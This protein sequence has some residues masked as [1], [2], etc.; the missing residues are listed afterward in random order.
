MK[1]M[2]TRSKFDVKSYQSR[3]K[4]DK[5]AESVRICFE[6]GSTLVWTDCIV[7]YEEEH[8]Y[9][10]GEGKQLMKLSKSESKS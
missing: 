8:S 3:T 2:Q 4:V 7:K 10:E 1:S 5:I 6:F 9:Y